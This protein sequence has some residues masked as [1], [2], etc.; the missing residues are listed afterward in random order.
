VDPLDIRTAYVYY[1][2]RVG[3]TTT[4]GSDWKAEHVQ[5]VIWFLEDELTATEVGN[6]S[7]Q[8]KM[9]RDQANLLAASYNFGGNVV[10]VINLVENDENGGRSQDL[11]TYQP[12]PEPGT[13]LM[14]GGGLLGLA[15]IARGRAKQ[16]APAAG[17]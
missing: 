1:A 6:L 2:F 13:M 8:A 11:L 15:G 17:K 12:V 9:I 16:Q 5:E 4:W 14:L 10:R 7:D 3:D